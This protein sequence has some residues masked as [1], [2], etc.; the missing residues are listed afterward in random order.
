VRRT[1]A[2]ISWMCK[3]NKPD[4]KSRVWLLARQEVDTASP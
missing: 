3:K 4:F 1:R 2:T